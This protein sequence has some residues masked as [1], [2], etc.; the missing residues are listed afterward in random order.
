MANSAWFRSVAAVDGVFAVHLSLPCIVTTM[1]N[2]KLNRNS[3]IRCLTTAASVVCV[4]ASHVVAA[5]V[6]VDTSALTE[7]VTVEGV[8]AHQEA[9]QQFADDNGGNREASSDGF[10]ESVTY[11]SNQMALAGYDVSLQLFPYI[12]FE[13]QTEPVLEQISPEAVTY[14]A[15]ELDGFATAT[16]SGSRHSTGS[17]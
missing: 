5:G 14:L 13:N 8:R 4:G 16:Y 15:N 6:G 11:V 9:F 12:F 10:Y 1:E 2:I 3:A 17:P 7:A